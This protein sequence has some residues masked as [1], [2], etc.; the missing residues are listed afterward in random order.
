MALP[1]FDSPAS[2]HGFLLDIAKRVPT[3]LTPEVSVNCRVLEV[4]ITNNTSGDITVLVQD[5]QGTAITLVPT[6]TVYAHGG[7]W[8]SSWRRGRLC[9]GGISWQASAGGLDGYIQ[10]V[11]S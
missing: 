10:A 5:N 6:I 3:S 11:Q 9:P 7:V 4:E 2:T 8:R 1:N